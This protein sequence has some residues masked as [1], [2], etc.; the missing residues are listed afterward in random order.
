MC[1]KNRI[2]G[3]RDLHLTLLLLSHAAFLNSLNLPDLPFHVENEEHN[4]FL[5]GIVMRALVRMK[6]KV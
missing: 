4:A 1:G 6:V 5:T 2:L 3:Q